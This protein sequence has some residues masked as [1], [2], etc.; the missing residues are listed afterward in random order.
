MSGRQKSSKSSSE[1]GGSPQVNRKESSKSGSSSQFVKVTKNGSTSQLSPATSFS[2]SMSLDS[3]DISRATGLPRTLFKRKGKIGRY[4][5]WLEIDGMMLKEYSSRNDPKPKSVEFLD[6]L[7]IEY[8]IIDGSTIGESEVLIIATECDGKKDTINYKAQSDEIHKIWF[9]YLRRTLGA[10]NAMNSKVR[11]GFN[12]EMFDDPSC[13]TDIDGIILDVNNSLCV[14]LGYEKKEL[15]GKPNT[16]LMPQIVASK[17]DW[18]MRNR[19]TRNESEHKP[20]C[21]HTCNAQHKNGRTIRVQISL[22]EVQ[23][24]SGKQYIAKMRDDTIP[25][26]GKDLDYMSTGTRFF[27]S[28][29][30]SPAYIPSIEHTKH[31]NKTN[32]KGESEHPPQSIDGECPARPK[33]RRANKRNIE[34]TDGLTDDQDYSSSSTTPIAS[35]VNTPTVSPIYARRTLRENSDDVEI[36]S[37]ADAILYDAIDGMIPAIKEALS[38]ANRL[39]NLKMEQIINAHRGLIQDKLEVERILMETEEEVRKLETI[40][41]IQDRALSSLI[42]ADTPDI[43]KDNNFPKSLTL[44]QYPLFSTLKSII[45]IELERSYDTPNTF[46]R[47]ESAEA[48]KI[49]GIF[50]SSGAEYLQSTLSDAIDYI[51]A[52]ID[53]L[54]PNILVHVA[55][56]DPVTRDINVY[57]AQRFIRRANRIIHDI[58]VSIDSLP[59][60]LKEALKFMYDGLKNN[61]QSKSGQAVASF[62]F[63]RFYIPVI[64]DPEKFGFI[65]TIA[66]LGASSSLDGIKSIDPSS[67]V[68][69]RAKCWVMIARIIQN[70]VNKSLLSNSD[71][72]S[73][74]INKYL[75]ENKGNIRDFTKKLLE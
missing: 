31:H 46:F 56:D 69:K 71:P 74:E 45:T 30:D 22:S 70:L 20:G 34:S 61:G 44:D 42:S 63:L 50:L 1:K 3:I 54:D 36:V 14:L 48:R 5:V 13:L 32:K 47:E 62:M 65:K 75:K 52:D 43:Y 8:T 67:I 39:T 25:N 72:A 23:T 6:S 15:I 27:D 26:L 2:S 66:S 28:L 51:Q 49:R 11:L 16:I 38:K 10:K 40:K 33:G 4:D 17:H 35:P 24:E 41:S 9:R 55:D 21:P 12:I 53:S 68:T 57:N 19:E 18:Y 73:K 29:D 64:A 59:V 7:T 58:I 37:H 60:I